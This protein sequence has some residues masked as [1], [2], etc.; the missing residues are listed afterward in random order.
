MPERQNDLSGAH[1][2]YPL[3]DGGGLEI[4]FSHDQTRMTFHFPNSETIEILDIYIGNSKRMILVQ[5]EP[6]ASLHGNEFNDLQDPSGLSPAGES[7]VN[8]DLENISFN[9]DFSVGNFLSAASISYLEGIPQDLMESIQARNDSSA[10]HGMRTDAYFSGIQQKSMDPNT[11]MDDGQS[12]RRLLNC[13]SCALGILSYASEI[14]AIATAPAN[15]GF[16]AAAALVLHPATVATIAIN[17]PKA[18]Q[19]G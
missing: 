16:G 3:R 18:V 6:L 8:K 2:Y 1:A 11:G 9:P 4:Q 13:V 5:G 10:A 7:K 19:G 15:L 17:C 12:S 14:A